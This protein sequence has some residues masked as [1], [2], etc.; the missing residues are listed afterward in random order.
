M[1]PQLH[2][3]L[4]SP[5]GLLFSSWV[6]IIGCDSSWIHL[7][8]LGGAPPKWGW[9]D[10]SVSALAETSGGNLY[11]PTEVFRAPPLEG[12]ELNLGRL[13]RGSYLRWF[14]M[15]EGHIDDLNHNLQEGIYFNIYILFIALYPVCVWEVFTEIHIYHSKCRANLFRARS[16]PLSLTTVSSPSKAYLRQSANLR[17]FVPCSP[18]HQDPR[19]RLLCWSNSNWRD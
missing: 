14:E 15:G 1:I 13:V 3:L 8:L 19:P 11:Y 16:S 6:G 12:P 7:I 17:I 2:R 10:N 18:C 4:R 9:L 5:I